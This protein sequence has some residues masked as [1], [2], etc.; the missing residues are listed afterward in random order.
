MSACRHWLLE[1]LRGVP[2]QH[3]SF[4]IGTHFMWAV[5]REL[6]NRLG[7]AELFLSC[8]RGAGFDDGRFECLG[9]SE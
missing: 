6:G 9:V 8:A 7:N 1:I 5:R 3:P 4:F 2:H